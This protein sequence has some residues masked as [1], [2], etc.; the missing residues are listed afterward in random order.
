MRI[1]AIHPRFQAARNQKRTRVVDIHTGEGWFLV[2]AAQVPRMK[3]NRIFPCLAMFRDFN[4]WRAAPKFGRFFRR[5][6]PP[7]SSRAMIRGGND[8]NPGGFYAVP[9]R[10]RTMTNQDE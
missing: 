1:R 10:P 2:R 3:G 5:G 9:G 8:G 6:C 4:Q 7:E